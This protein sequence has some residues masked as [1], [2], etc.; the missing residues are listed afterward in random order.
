M[1]TKRFGIEFLG[2]ALAILRKRSGK[3][4]SEVALEIG[5]SHTG[6]SRYENGGRELTS[7]ILFRY[8]DAVNATF[9]DLHEAIQQVRS[10]SGEV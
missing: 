8:L 10:A 3:T 9:V 7:R 6:V 4:A 2:P 1:D 5:R